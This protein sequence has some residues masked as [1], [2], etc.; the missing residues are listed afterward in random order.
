MSNRPAVTLPVVGGHVACPSGRSVTIDKCRFCVHST[1]FWVAGKEVP[2]PARAYCTMQR[3]SE[4]VDLTL[5]EAVVC[6][7][8]SGE[9][10][11]SI[12]NIIS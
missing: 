9:G 6:D 8:V 2:S 7:D 10:Y 1:R 4:E 3:K 12:M 11:R 5:V